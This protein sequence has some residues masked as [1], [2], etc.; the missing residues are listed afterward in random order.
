MTKTMRENIDV[1]F[2]VVQDE[3]DRNDRGLSTCT[4]RAGENAEEASGEAERGREGA[5]R[6]GRME[7]SARE[8]DGGGE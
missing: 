6:R 7:R 1:E 3:G 5:S 4:K 2:L 8:R